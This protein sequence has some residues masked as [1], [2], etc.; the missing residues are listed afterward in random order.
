MLKLYQ[1]AG[2]QYQLQLQQTSAFR[3][4]NLV[5]LTFK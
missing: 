5:S 2:Q 1:S 3:T 4:H